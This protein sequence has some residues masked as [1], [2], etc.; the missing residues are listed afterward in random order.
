MFFMVLLVP[1]LSG[2]L[3]T[4][5]RLAYWHWESAG[6]HNKV[7]GKRQRQIRQRLLARRNACTALVQCSVTPQLGQ[8]WFLRFGRSGNGTLSRSSQTSLSSSR[9]RRC[10]LAQI[11]SQIPRFPRSSFSA[12]SSISV[13]PARGTR[14]QA[15]RSMA[16]ART[17]RARR[18]CLE[19]S[20]R[21]PLST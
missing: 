16:S 12:I 13:S 21:T 7:L 11:V 3:P 5:R 17:N 9:N 20:T 10:L 6:S 18:C 1:V 2:R 4:W 8:G 15:T 19:V 14:P